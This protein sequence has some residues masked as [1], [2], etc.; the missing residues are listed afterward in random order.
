MRFLFYVRSASNV[1]SSSDWNFITFQSLL[2]H[3]LDQYSTK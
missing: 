1:L 3:I 2:N